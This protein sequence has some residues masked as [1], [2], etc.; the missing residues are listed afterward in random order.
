MSKKH[1]NLIFRIFV[2]MCMISLFSA[3]TVA[4]SEEAKINDGVYIDS[5]H[6]GGMTAGEAKNA[7]NEYIDG[8]RT[9]TITV[10]VEEDSEQITLDELGFNYKDHDYIEQALTIGESGNLLKRYKE[11]K[12]IAHNNLIFSLEYTLD[13]SAVKEFVETKLS[14]YDIAAQNASVKREG[15]QF[16]YSDHVVGR[17]VQVEETIR[18]IEESIN[19]GWD[20]ANISLS[21]VVLEDAPEYT[22]DDVEK[23]NSALGSFTTNYSSSSSS[24]AANLA[25]GA[26]LINNTL[27]YPG[28]EF[29]A[30]DKLAPF[31]I[32]NGYSV[33]GAYENGRL[34]DSIGGGA[35][36]VTT[37]LYN[38][39][40]YAEMDITERA[41]HS[42]TVSYV[43]LA[44]DAAIAGTYKNLRFVNNTA[45]PVL[46]QAYT[47]N[48]NITFTIW[49]HE[50]R[51]ENRKIEYKTVVLSKR[52]P[53]ADV[54]TEDPTLPSTYKKTT[55]S[56]HT[57]YVAEL[58]KIEYIDGKEVSREFVNKSSYMASPRY[59]TIGTMPE[60]TPTPEPTPDPNQETIGQEP[61]QGQP[62][63]SQ[64]DQGQPGVSQPDTQSTKPE[65]GTSKQ[66]DSEKPPKTEAE[67]N[68]E[69]QGE[70]AEAQAP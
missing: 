20:K 50:T 65:P 4:A 53:P 27:L 42:M 43:D 6:I 5:V 62:D 41:A 21:A 60:P 68:N 58:Y 38:A 9:T 39:A 3:T 51:P 18:L 46:I 25:N 7:V 8:L 19:E 59:V 48:R 55:Q 12:D 49:G 15:G 32:S 63:T 33:G 11:I 47:K 31:T 24:R 17:H 66:A 16:I 10:M 35:C 13:N 57:G 23:V 14:A 2:A 56:P 1:L 29:N 70:G 28:D 26:K 37:T 67:A 36:Q 61:D 44:R 30:Y 69:S 40:L 54:V 64:P 34:V 45:Y 22:R 52:N